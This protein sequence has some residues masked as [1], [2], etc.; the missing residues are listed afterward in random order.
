MCSF[1]QAQDRLCS[2]SNWH[3]IAVE[4]SVCL[5][6]SC[7]RRLDMEQRPMIKSYLKSGKTATEMH[8]DLKKKI[9]R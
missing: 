4:V 6:V 3:F 7:V 1:L 9:V 2:F 5:F 8:Q